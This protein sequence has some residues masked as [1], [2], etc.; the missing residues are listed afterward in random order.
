MKWLRRIVTVLL[1]VL[2]AL[3]AYGIVLVRK[4]FP[5]TTGEVAI[6]GLGNPVRVTRDIDGV[7]HIYAES[8]RDMFMAQGYV[9]AQDRFWQMDVWRHI[10]AGRVSEMFGKSQIE[11]DM[12]LRSLGFVDLA[13]QEMRSMDTL[14]GEILQWYAD[15]VNAYLAHH[16]GADISL[17]YAVL[18][19]QNPGYRI[20]PWNPVNTLTWARLM[21]W[22]L[23]GNMADEIDRS[24]LSAR[25][26]PGRLEQLYPDFPEDHPSIIPAGVSTVATRRPEL[27]PADAIGA[28][29]SAGAAAHKVWDLTGGGF[30]GIGSNSWVIAGSRTRTGKPILANDPHLAIQMPSIWYEI[31]LHC[32][33]DG[34]DCLQDRMGFSFPGTPGIVVGHNEHIAWGV[35]NASVDTQ[36]LF[37]E[38]INPDDPNQYEVDG[39]WADMELRDETIEVAGSDSVNYQ[40][41]STRHGPV[42][43]GLYL[44]EGALDGSTLDL[45]DDY[46]VALSWQTLHPST[47]VNSVVWLNEA[48]DYEDFK[49]AVSLWD[50]AAQNVIYADIEG[51]IAFQSTGEIPIRARG[52]GRWPVPGWNSEYEWTGTVPTDEMPGLLN[53]E[54]GYIETANQPATRLGDGPFESLDGDMGYRAQR[55]DELINSRALHTVDSV[56]RMQ[57]DAHDGGAEWLVPHLLNLGGGDAPIVATIADWAKESEPYQAGAD[58]KGA[59][60]YEVV[61]RNVLALTFADELP[62]EQWPYGGDR[63]FEVVRRLLDTPEDAWWDDAGTPGVETRDDILVAALASAGDELAGML[64]VNP[65]RWAWGKLHVAHFDNQTLGQSGIAPIEWLFNRTAPLRVGGGPAI[66]NATGWDAGHSYMVDWVPSF[67]MVVDL[68]DFANSTGLHTTGQSGHAYN[69]H[70][71]DMLGRWA[72]GIQAPLRWTTGQVDRDQ[73]ATLT[74]IPTTLSAA[75]PS[76]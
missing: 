51:N 12:F 56:Q 17:E 73:A 11:T 3:G 50:I 24:V 4:S 31:G 67:R 26:P 5:Q 19:L 74:L 68:S 30:Q 46:V 60:A 39:E 8:A 71:A 28:L 72:D 1:V 63:W 20:E 43:S 9:E 32:T 69:A 58:S 27:P 23:S 52:D 29:V 48:T 36:D 70:Y 49:K 44:D 2:V 59:A 62:E 34:P 10:G 75:G 22:D 35:T 61:W 13:E 76:G 65:K 37:I 38:K 18:R 25:I 33:T 45:P 64:G 6:P 15:G 57:M 14:T 7:P 55:I 16:E 54:R 40:V 21:S 66:I 41:R 42:I 53:P 47:L